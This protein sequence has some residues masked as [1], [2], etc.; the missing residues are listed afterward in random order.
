MKERW[1]VG[2]IRFRGTGEGVQDLP[3]RLEKTN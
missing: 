2:T 1:L 3:F